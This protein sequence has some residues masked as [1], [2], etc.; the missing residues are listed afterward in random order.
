MLCIM[1]H[2]EFNFMI[3]GNKNETEQCDISMLWYLVEIIRFMT[4]FRLLPMLQKM[5]S[6]K[7]QISLL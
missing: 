6:Q 5:R 7:K 1:H 4:E 2:N 3:H